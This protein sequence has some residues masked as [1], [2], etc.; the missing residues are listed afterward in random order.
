MDFKGLS[1][2][3]EVLAGYSRSLIRA[4]NILEVLAGFSWILEALAG[5]C[6][7]LEVLEGF[8]WIAVALAGF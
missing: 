7:I 4:S 6:V 2:N 1:T 5:I 3:L 8:S